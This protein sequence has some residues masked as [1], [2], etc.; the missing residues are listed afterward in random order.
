MGE[1][2]R[3]IWVKLNACLHTETLKFKRKNTET[4]LNVCYISCH[5]ICMPL[6]EEPSHAYFLKKKKKK[7]NI[8]KGENTRCQLKVCDINHA[9][10][11]FISQLRRPLSHARFFCISMTTTKQSYH[12]KTCFVFFFHLQTG[13]A[14]ITF[15]IRAA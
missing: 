6:L 4:R 5:M 11:G 8:K 2:I 9:A 1:S 3:Q 13:R 15:I 10:T 7:K 12:L 14:Q